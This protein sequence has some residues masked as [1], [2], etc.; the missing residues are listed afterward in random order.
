MQTS[1]EDEG[2]WYRERSLL[3]LADR[4][5]GMRQRDWRLTMLWAVVGA[6]ATWLA[7]AGLSVLVFGS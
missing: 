7:V 4:R 1:S 2:R 6:L 3:G 5:H